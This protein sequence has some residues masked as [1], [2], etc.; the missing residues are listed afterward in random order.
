MKQNYTLKNNLRKYK[1]I[2]IMLTKKLHHL[3]F[4]N[5]RYILFYHNSI[6]VAQN[7]GEEMALIS[8]NS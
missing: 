1:K 8:I 7:A 6:S 2:K 4:I 5:I 3:K